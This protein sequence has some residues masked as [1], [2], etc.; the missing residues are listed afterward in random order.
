MCLTILDTFQLKKKMYFIKKK[1]ISTHLKYTKYQYKKDLQ[2]ESQLNLN[3]IIIL[4]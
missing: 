3:I 4:Q 2:N 1:Y